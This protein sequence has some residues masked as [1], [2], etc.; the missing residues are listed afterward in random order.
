MKRF[1][2]MTG[3]V[4]TG[5]ITS[6][7]ITGG[8]SIPAFASRVGLPVGIALGGTGILLSLATV[9]TETSFKILTV[10]QKKQDTIKLLAQSKSD[11]ITNI[12]SLA[13]QDGDIAPIEF[14][15]LLQEVQRYC[16]L[17]AN[18]RNQAKPKVKEITK[19]KARK[20]FYKKSQTLQVP[21]VPMPFKI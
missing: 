2:T 18:V 3:I 4:D 14:H 8:I 6:T 1:N 16:K 12:I 5:L 17:K 19:E 21:R 11:S 7:V 9:I 20:I 13:M 10:K 15:K